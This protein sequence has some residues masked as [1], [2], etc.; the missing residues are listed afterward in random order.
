M[1]LV[2]LLRNLINLLPLAAAANPTAN[3]NII[4]R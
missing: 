3:H 2:V 4:T 1:S